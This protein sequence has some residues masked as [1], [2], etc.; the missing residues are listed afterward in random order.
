MTYRPADFQQGRTYRSISSGWLFR[1][2][3]Y[4]QVEAYSNYYQEW[5]AVNPSKGSLFTEVV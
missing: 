5:Q 4:Y 3:L 2:N 1:V